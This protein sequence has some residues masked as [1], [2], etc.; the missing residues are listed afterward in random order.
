MK[1]SKLDNIF[2]GIHQ[3]SNLFTKKLWIKDVT[4]HIGK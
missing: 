3:L 4:F 1:K 2:D